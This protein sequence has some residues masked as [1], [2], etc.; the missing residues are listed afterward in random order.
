MAVV[1]HWITSRGTLK[2]VIELNT[3]LRDGGCWL[4]GFHHNTG[5]QK[6]I[7]LHV[8]VCVCECVCVC[9]CVCVM[10]FVYDGGG[11]GVFLCVHAVVVCVYDPV[12]VVCVCVCDGFCV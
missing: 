10:V 11:C 2:I 5:A 9:L 8:C 1:R 3:C 7:F 4:H 6:L 12:F